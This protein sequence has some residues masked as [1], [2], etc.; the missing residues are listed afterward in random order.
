M[1]IEDLLTTANVR[2]GHHHLTVEP[3]GTQQGGVKHVGAVGR[4][5]DDSPRVGLETIHLDQQLVERLF[6]LVVTA[7]ETCPALTTH[8]VDFIDEDDAGRL[9]FG[10]LKHVAHTRRA[11]TD[12]HLDEIRTRDAEERHLRLTSNGFGEQRLAGTGATDH[13]HATRDAPAQFLEA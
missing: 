2:Q 6:A 3:A 1:D 13:Q 12:E 7:A 8:G 11:N 9:L 5:D 4:G 10:G